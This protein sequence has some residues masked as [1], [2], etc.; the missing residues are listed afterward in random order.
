MLRDTIHVV[1]AFVLIWPSLSVAQTLDSSPPSSRTI[2]VN[3][4]EFLEQSMIPSSAMAAVFAKPEAMLASPG[5]EV[6]PRE[7][8]TV[9]GNKQLGFDPCQ[10]VDASLLV[11]TITNLKQPPGFALVLCFERPQQP[12]EQLTRRYDK[13][14][15]DGK[16]IYRHRENEPAILQFDARTIIFG[17]EPFIKKMLAARGAQSK[18]ISLI[19]TKNKDAQL[20]A[21][22]TVEPIRGLLN[23]KLPRREEVPSSM[24]PFLRL[25]DLM[26]SISLK[27]NYGENP[28]SILEIT[29]VNENACLEMASI[30]RRGIQ[31]GSELAI[32]Q[33]AREMRDQDPDLQQAVIQYAE[34]ISRYLQV[35]F[36][37]IVVDKSLHFQSDGNNAQLANVAVI[38]S[39]VGMLL[40]AVQQ[41]REAARRT[42]S[43]NNL[44]Q[45]ALA[46]LNYEAAYRKFPRNIV[47]ADG[48]P[49]LS[50]RVAIL[51]FLEENDLYEQF[52]LEEPW[53][54]VHNLQLLN[55][56]P[57][58]F[59]NPN[60]ASEQET[61]YLGFR[62]E[63]TVF[64]NEEVSF[65]KIVDG[66]SNTILAVEANIEAAVEW[67]RPADIPFAAEDQVSGVGQL[68]PGG[69][70]AAFC[71]GST[72]FISQS[73]KQQALKRL[74]QRN[75]GQLNDS[76]NAI[77][78]P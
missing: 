76:D 6:F 51:P 46:C 26:E 47:D 40:P 63:G 37:P 36:E 23:E 41:A 71:D 27:V 56:M 25:P 72:R 38:G 66:S 74:I 9:M 22:V 45:I 18:L 29:G 33:M 8:V 55:R 30:L 34:R 31:M 70:L 24:Q 20:S 42:Q 68:R 54:S 58:A 60:F 19:E 69:F 17:M 65:A 12:G 53:N 75:D 21:F 43:M 3:F 77:R 67:S 5:M 78:T 59:K 13:G 7:I 28:V 4:Q 50:W 64:G 73:L 10:I 35:S 11:D 2:M 16:A 62:G 39:L 52:N 44:R 14:T 1:S 49:L 15:L 61:V 32:A 48:N 57:R